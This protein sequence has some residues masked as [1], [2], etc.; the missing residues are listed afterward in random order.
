[1]STSLKRH[2]TPGAKHPERAAVMLRGAN[3]V[4]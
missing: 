4:L 2:P 3:H 1:M